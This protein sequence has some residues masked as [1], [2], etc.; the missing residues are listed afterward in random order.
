M[1]ILTV[2]QINAKKGSYCFVKK[3]ITYH[4][5]RRKELIDSGPAF[6]AILSSGGSG[7][8]P[9]LGLRFVHGS[10]NAGN[11]QFSKMTVSALVTVHSKVKKDWNQKADRQHAQIEGGKDGPSRVSWRRVWMIHSVVCVVGFGSSEQCKNVSILETVKTFNIKQNNTV[12]TSSVRWL[13]MWSE[14]R[15]HLPGSCQNGTKNPNNARTHRVASSTCS[16][17]RVN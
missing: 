12:D 6:F 16:V 3:T 10:S 13:M 2:T 7:F 15:H 4:S 1:Y 11:F 14:E 5:N 8:L 17:R 9:V